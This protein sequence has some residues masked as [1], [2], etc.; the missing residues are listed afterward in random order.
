MLVSKE[1]GRGSDPNEVSVYGR[2]I[3]TEEREERRER[4]VKMAQREGME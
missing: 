2:E 1:G 3:G 4:R